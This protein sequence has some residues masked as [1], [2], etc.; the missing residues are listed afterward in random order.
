ME[1]NP[2]SVIKCGGGGIF[3]VFEGQSIWHDASTKSSVGCCLFIPFPPYPPMK[4]RGYSWF[5]CVWV[6]SGQYLHNH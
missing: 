6:L 2:I 1:V 3:V 5:V 4:L